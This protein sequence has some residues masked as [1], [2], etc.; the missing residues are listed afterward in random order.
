MRLLLLVVLFALGSV[1]AQGEPGDCISSWNCGGYP[2]AG[3]T[4]TYVWHYPV[5]QG[6]SVPTFL[7]SNLGTTPVL[8]GQC[9]EGDTCVGVLY[10][11]ATTGDVAGTAAACTI[12]GIGEE[13]QCLYGFDASFVANNQYVD[14]TAG[15]GG[16]S[17]G[18]NSG[19]VVVVETGFDRL[20][21]SRNCPGC[22]GFICFDPS[23]P[24]DETDGD[25]DGTPVVSTPFFNVGLVPFIGS[26]LTAAQLTALGLTQAAGGVTPLGPIDVTCSCPAP[27]GCNPLIKSQVVQVAT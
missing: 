6:N 19:G 25:C 5:C 4:N 16:T 13:N 26:T 7:L 9:K 18:A 21:D 3:T 11:F 23:D 17:A 2:A 1:L 10:S 24:S 27:D 20:T 14:T 8:E 15:S 12:E 22:T